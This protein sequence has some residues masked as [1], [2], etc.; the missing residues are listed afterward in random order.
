MDRI[1]L[2]KKVGGLHPKKFQ[3]QGPDSNL[4]LFWFTMLVC[5]QNAHVAK[6]MTRKN[7][8]L[9]ENCVISGTR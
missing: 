4:F 6:T 9:Y 5:A 7:K 2:K 8:L 1:L 3:S